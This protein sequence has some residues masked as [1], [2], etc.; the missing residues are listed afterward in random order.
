MLIA[1]DTAMFNKQLDE[2]EDITFNL[3][4]RLY[5]ESVTNKLQIYKVLSNLYLTSNS[6][7]ELMW[8]DLPSL[9]SPINLSERTDK[10]VIDGDEIQL[11]TVKS[12]HRNVPSLFLEKSLQLMALAKIL[13]IDVFPIPL[14]PANKYA[15]DILLLIMELKL[16]LK[17]TY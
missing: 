14:G 10:L 6:L 8:S 7:D 3:V 4:P 17:L 5:I 15:C 1:K 16:Y 2:L 9:I 12:I 13:A 11:V